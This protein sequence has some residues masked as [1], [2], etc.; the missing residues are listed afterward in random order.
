M[1]ISPIFAI[2]SERK[3]C[4]FSFS[5]KT[6]LIQP[7]WGIHLT[8]IRKQRETNEQSRLWHKQKKLCK[9]LRQFF[10]FFS[11][12]KISKGKILIGCVW[13]KKIDRGSKKLNKLS[14]ENFLQKKTTFIN[15]YVFIVPVFRPKFCHCHVLLIYSKKKVLSN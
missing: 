7:R 1:K 14:E 6:G 11:L 5:C 12:K 13:E 4:S 8:Y 10:C 9:K 3:R 2:R 15:W